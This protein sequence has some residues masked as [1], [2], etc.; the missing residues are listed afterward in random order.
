MSSELNP[1]WHQ[2]PRRVTLRDDENVIYK[3]TVEHSKCNTEKLKLCVDVSRHVWLVADST[4]RL[5]VSL[6]VRRDE[7]KVTLASGHPRC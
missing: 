5:L 2:L 1:K 3:M 4:G 6:P 7:G